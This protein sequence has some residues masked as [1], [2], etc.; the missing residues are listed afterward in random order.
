MNTPPRH[1]ITT[2]YVKTERTKQKIKEQKGSR[3]G[4][5][6][7]GKRRSKTMTVEKNGPAIKTKPSSV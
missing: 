7:Q 5:E 6:L 4:S 1:S 3:R 2:D